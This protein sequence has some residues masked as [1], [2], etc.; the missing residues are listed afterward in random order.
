MYIDNYFAIGGAMIIQFSFVKVTTY[1]VRPN[2]PQRSF[3]N[4]GMD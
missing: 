1:L 3:R 4:A 2:Y